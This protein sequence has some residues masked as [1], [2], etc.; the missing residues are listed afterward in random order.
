ML[1]SKQLSPLAAAMLL[2][3]GLAQAASFTQTGA[4]LLATDVSA[5]G[6]VV[7]GS[8]AVSGHY[9]SWTAEAGL[10]DIG[11]KAAGNG[12]GGSP[13]ISA[14]ASRVSGVALNAANNSYEMAYRNMSTGQWTTLGGI[15][16]SNGTTT[17]EVSAGWAISDNGQFV[18]GAA[19]APGTA[20]GRGRASVWSAS[21]NAIT[22]L[23]DSGITGGNNSTRAAAVSNDGKTVV[24]WGLGRRPMLWTDADGDGSY[25][26]TEI[27]SSSGGALS[28]ATDM[29]SDG[30]WVVG[31]GSTGNAKQA[32]R[33]SAATGTVDLGT[34]MPLGAV[35]SA[36]AVSEDGMTVLGYERP[37]G[38]AS[39]SF[40]KGFIWTAAAG[41]KSFDA[42]LASYGI[43]VGDSFNFSTPL[44]MSADGKTF[45]GFGNVNGSPSS[46]GFI[47]N[48]AAA[49][50]EPSSYVMLAGGLFALAWLAKRRKS[51]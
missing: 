1:I 20:T 41:M 25:V 38:A 16:G 45:V 8:N 26:R 30:K 21:S 12:V 40:G 22:N 31:M 5:D 49:V 2:A 44:A 19:W 43:D 3:S 36:T 32:W 35:G 6:R 4:G 28:E 7:V 34:L 27:M 10:V 33:W 51:V 46:V 24:G 50:P 23:G 39:A 9:F 47:V 42:F 14:D 29:S 37:Q 11:G 17:V 13:R 18:A 48:I 15:G